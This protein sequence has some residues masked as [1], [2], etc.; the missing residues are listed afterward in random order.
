MVTK[1]P[2]FFLFISGCNLWS[3]TEGGECNFYGH[4]GSFCAMCFVVGLKTISKSLTNLRHFFVGP[5][6]AIKTP[7]A[8][9]S[10]F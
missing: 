7:L 8:S 10:S 4:A 6:I 9:V 5:F 3:M 2:F 1:L